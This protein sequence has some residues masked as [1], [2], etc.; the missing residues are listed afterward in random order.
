MLSI[1]PGRKVSSLDSTYIK[2]EGI[3]SWD[4]MERAASAFCSLLFDKLSSVPDNVFIFSGPGNNGGDGIAIARLLSLRVKEVS[5]IVFEE[6]QNCSKDYQI[7]FEKLPAQVQVFGWDEFAFAFEDHDLIIDGIFGV[8]INRP[9]EGKY[10]VVIEKLNAARGIKI[11]IDIPSGIPSDNL[12]QGTAF[13]ADYTI[14][15]QFPKLALLFPEHAEY[16]GEIQ[17]ADIGIPDH[18]LEQF[19]EKRYFLT[20]DYVKSLHKTFNRFSH[21]G[22]F[23]KILLVG[24][25]RGKVGAILLSSKA[26]LRT[27][28]GLVFALV[29]EDE[30]LILQIGAPEV[31]LANQDEIKGLQIFDALGVGPG[32]GQEIDISFYESLLKRYHKPLVIDADGLNL[33]SSHAKLMELVPKGSILTPH[34]KEFER[35][36]GKVDNHLERLQ[37]ARDFSEKHNVYLVLKGQFSSI[38][39]PDGRQFFNSTG[40]Q[41]MATAGSGDVLTGMITSFLGQGYSP[42]NAALCGVYHH[43]LAGEFASETRLRGTIAGDIIESIPASFL[44]LGIA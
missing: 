27:G 29:P 32:W 2:E 39:C 4:L 21:K 19:G 20:P 23:G 10:K 7:N 41:Y 3:S 33:L 9:V 25:S 11:A 42:L 38:T 43:G 13:K 34:I 5:L 8:G 35:L 15:F 16:S 22:N 40:N 1:I 24:G 44:K 17:V 14:T 26:A 31:I 37:K 36:T 30:R 28:S 18:F 12:L 6:Y